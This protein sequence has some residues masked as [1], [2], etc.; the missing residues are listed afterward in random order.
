[1][2]AP[3]TAGEVAVGRF[4]FVHEAQAV[5]DGAR[6]RTYEF[7]HATFGEYLVAR[8][9]GRELAALAETAQLHAARGRA[10]PLDDA[11]LHA[12]LSFSA[13]AGRGTVVE[14]LRE[15]LASLSAAQ[16]GVLK[17][18]LLGLFHQALLP[19]RS[20]AYD[21]YLPATY[22]PGAQ[23]VPG[24]HAAWSANLATLVVLVSG[25]VTAHELFP[26][27]LDGVT[28]WRRMA[29]L[30]RSQL[31]GEGWNGM[32]HALDVLRE[33]DGGAR[34]VRIRPATGAL[35]V[36]PIDLNWVYPGRPGHRDGMTKW[37]YYSFEDL[38][39]HNQFLCDRTDDTVLYAA[40]PFGGANDAMAGAVYAFTG[41]PA[42][43]PAG[44]LVGLLMADDE[45]LID[46]YEKCLL[47][48][49]HGG[50]DATRAEAVAL[51][52]FHAVLSRMLAGD[53]DRLPADWLAA[54]VH[55]LD[56][57]S[58]PEEPSPRHRDE[59]G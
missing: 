32:V 37:H 46:A 20:H 58:D 17:E 30:W 21:A 50:R 2:R 29:L 13:L 41:G 5:R 55:Q 27:S 24:R 56:S 42:L 14:F 26:E 8:L 49:R 34:V 19:R 10:T 3:L 43:T 9:V 54:A 52:R 28:W 18:Q 44:A 48:A 51:R 36:P 22:H 38:R 39:R 6:L 4:Y 33:W 7:L 47:I 59:P 31:P 16:S 11:F 1:M 57:V 25:G 35:P 12:L 53:R 45:H 40:E 15:R 23:T